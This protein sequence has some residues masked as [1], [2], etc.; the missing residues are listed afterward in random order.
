MDT[1]PVVR[2][3]ARR[4]IFGPFPILKG[5]SASDNGRG[6]KE[7]TSIVDGVDFTAISFPWLLVIFVSP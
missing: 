5:G 6:K 2:K 7:K 3:L 4:F 1:S